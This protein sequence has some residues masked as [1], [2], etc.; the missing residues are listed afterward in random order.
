MNISILVYQDEDGVFIGEVPSL[1]GVHS[2]GKTK[3]ELYLNLQE[4]IELYYEVQENEGIS[5]EEI[6]TPHYQLESLTLSYAKTQNSISQ[7]TSQV[8]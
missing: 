7:K 8:A 6:P 4:A 1:K 3:E 2:F 5:R